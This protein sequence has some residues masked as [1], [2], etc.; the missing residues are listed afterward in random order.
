M[1]SDICQSVAFLRTGA[2]AHNV[3]VFGVTGAV[4]AYETD[5]S[6]F[7]LSGMAAACATTADALRHFEWFAG[8][9][10]IL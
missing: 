10:P 8:S 1:I 3:D 5:L 9:A 2:F 4:G 6:S 7:A